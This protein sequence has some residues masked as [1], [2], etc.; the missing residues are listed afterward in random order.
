MPATA[1]KEQDERLTRI[2]KRVRRIELLTRGMVK[3][4]LGGSITHA[5]KARAS[6]SMISVN[7]KPGMM[8]DSST[9]MSPLA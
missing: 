6:S 3:E 7:I 2:L 1:T 9:G 5:S 8:C 4:V